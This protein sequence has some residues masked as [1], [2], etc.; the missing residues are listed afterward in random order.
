MKDRRGSSM[1]YHG[2]TVPLL[3]T[4]TAKRIVKLKFDGGE[5][6]TLIGVE[7]KPKVIWGM[8]SWIRTVYNCSSVPPPPPP[9]AGV[10]AA[11]TSLRNDDETSGDAIPRSCGKLFS[12]RRTLPPCERG[13]RCATALRQC[14]SWW[15]R[16]IATTTTTV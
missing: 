3:P 2:Q 9:P 8:G 1:E 4:I 7:L 14:V 15:A 16:A 10:G 13:N 6:P 11:A 5:I 12:C